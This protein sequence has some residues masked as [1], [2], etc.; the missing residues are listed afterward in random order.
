MILG[1][2]GASH[3]LHTSRSAH[4]NVRGSH[5]IDVQK[6]CMSTSQRFMDHTRQVEALHSIRALQCLF[7]SQSFEEKDAFRFERALNFQ[8]VAL[9]KDKRALNFTRDDL[10]RH[11]FQRGALFEEEN[12]EKFRRWNLQ[13]IHRGALFKEENGGKFGTLVQAI[14]HRQEVAEKICLLGNLA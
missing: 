2:Q 14:V 13:I 12:G 4:T 10:L 5:H 1:L 7:L 8:R 9:F 3:L 11:L 6:D